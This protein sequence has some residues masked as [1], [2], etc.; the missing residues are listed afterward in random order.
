[1]VTAVRAG[2][3]ALVVATMVMVLTVGYS[4]SAYAT[5]VYRGPEGYEWYA[6]FGNDYFNAYNRL[7]IEKE[8][9]SELG[10]GNTKTVRYTFTWNKNKDKAA[11][12]QR[13]WLFVYLPKDL[14]DGTLKIS[15]YRED[16]KLGIRPGWEEVTVAKNQ[17]I[18]EFHTGTGPASSRNAGLY[19]EELFNKHW[20]E[21]FGSTEPNPGTDRGFGG[22][23]PTTCEMTGWKNDGKFGRSLW[24]WENGRNQ[25]H[26]WVV[27]AVVPSSFDIDA[28]PVLMGYSSSNIAGFERFYMGYGPFDT[29]NDGIPDAKE[30]HAGTNPYGASLTYD[31]APLDYGVPSSRTP[32]AKTGEINQR[33]NNYE[34][35]EN[36]GTSQAVPTG[37][38]YTL[39]S[40]L[41]AGVQETSDRTQM[42]PGRVFLDRQTGEL[43]FHPAEE[44]SG[45]TVNFEINVEFP[46]KTTCR[47]QLKETLKA[48]FTVKTP[49]TRDYNPQYAPTTVQAGTTKNTD[50]PKDPNKDL[51]AGTTFA[52]T[53]QAKKDFPWAT[54]DATTGVITLNPE[55]RL[56]AKDYVIPVVVTYPDTSTTTIN[57]AVTVTPPAPQKG[58]FTVDVTETEVWLQAGHPLVPELKVKAQS[59]VQADQ[60]DVEMVCSLAGQ[61]TDVNQQLS[62]GW[63]LDKLTRY[64]TA[65]PEQQQKLDNGGSREPGV[66]YQGDT[67]LA[68]T[69]VS[70]AGLAD[71]P[72]VY[73][74]SFFGSN[75]LDTIKKVGLLSNGK[76]NDASGVFEGARGI[77]W[78]S[79]TVT[80][81]VVEPFTLPKTGGAGV[82]PVLALVCVGGMVLIGLWFTIATLSPRPA[83][84]SRTRVSR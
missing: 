21:G 83:R 84:S 44:H 40:R 30:T 72:G 42:G 18:G 14:Q 76:I 39:S 68:R 38:T 71:K 65:T 79:K 37:A 2:L 58:D 24:S 61:E 31:T 23:S 19:P 75:K 4:A 47:P 28:E 48:S 33:A 20:N 29:D 82:M 17:S 70:V 5:D 50:A 49:L 67:S 77:A 9:V 8:V 1:M 46:Q 41:P 64:T 43:V 54:I 73:T 66:L 6:K 62:N 13:P 11:F 74:C 15:R 27:E 34:F 80:V 57:A 63:S 69:D 12:S 7:D 59:A 35:W 60:I 16:Y 52:L 51:P 56:T 10:V 53:E 25:V 81:H 45:Q 32:L 78:D 3:R 26:K 55:R 36:G 22:H